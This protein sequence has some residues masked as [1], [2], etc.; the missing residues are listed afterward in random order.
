MRERKSSY[1]PETLSSDERSLCVKIV[2]KAH[3]PIGIGQCDGLRSQYQL[4][5]RPYSPW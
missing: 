4:L 3:V 2:N 1:L 5:Y